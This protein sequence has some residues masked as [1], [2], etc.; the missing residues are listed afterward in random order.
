MSS[1][2]FLALDP[3]SQAEALRDIFRLYGTDDWTSEDIRHQVY[4][5]H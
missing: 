4:G 2:A 3:E 1:P 5:E